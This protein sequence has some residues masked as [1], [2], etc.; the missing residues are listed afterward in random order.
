MSNIEIERKFLVKGN[1][2]KHA[3]SSQRIVQ[4]YICNQPDKNVR[5]RIKGDKA[6]ITIKGATNQSGTS[7]FEWEKEISVAE[8]EL[9]LPLCE[10]GVI[11][12]VRYYVDVGLHTYEVDEF[13]GDNQGLTIAEIELQSENEPFEKPEWLGAEVT[14]EKRYYNVM[15]VQCPFTKWNNND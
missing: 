3:A 14:G 5:I 15:L 8:A 12:K 11:D 2:K 10:S 13:C 1:Y 7:R 6:Y 9:L 4:G